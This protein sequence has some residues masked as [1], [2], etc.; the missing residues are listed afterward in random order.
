MEAFLYCHFF[1]N[2]GL[3]LLRLPRA[4]LLNPTQSIGLHQDPRPT[5]SEYKGDLEL[6]KFAAWLGHQSLSTSRPTSGAVSWAAREAKEH[7]SQLTT[8]S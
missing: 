1:V 4:S 7:G 2:Q 6:V 5:A 8:D 3:F